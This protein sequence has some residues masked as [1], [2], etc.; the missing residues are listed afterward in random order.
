MRRVPFPPEDGLW[1][2]RH[3]LRREPE[4]DEWLHAFREQ[5][6]IEAIDAAP[7]VLDARV[8]TRAEVRDASTSMECA[9]SSAAMRRKG[10]P[11]WRL[12]VRIASSGYSRDSIIPLL[13]HPKPTANRG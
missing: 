9:P 4:L 3:H 8:E 7:V 5:R 13:I 6:G 1:R 11:N 2:C 12:S 10:L